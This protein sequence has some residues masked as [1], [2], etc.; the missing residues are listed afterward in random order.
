MTETIRETHLIARPGEA[1][2]T[3]LRDFDAT[4]ELVFRAYS[5]PELYV[6]WHACDAMEIVAE[7]FECRTGGSYRIVETVVG[8]DAY[9]VRGVFHEVRNPGLI[10]KTIESASHP[11]HVALEVTRFEALPDK[12]TRMTG[13]TYLQSVAKRDEWVRLGVEKG[14]RE[15]HGYLRALLQELSQA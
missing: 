4:P 14:T 11:G 5:E 15:A 10:V 1:S 2:Y 12:R 9:A 6:R 3:V 7:K 8:A 13:I